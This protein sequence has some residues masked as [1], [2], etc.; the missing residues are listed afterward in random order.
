M[1]VERLGLYLPHTVDDP[2]GRLS[3]LLPHD[4]FGAGVERGAVARSLPGL[5]LLAESIR[6]KTNR[7]PMAAVTS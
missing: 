6:T 4:D 1:V 7:S 3:Q 2:A 5:A